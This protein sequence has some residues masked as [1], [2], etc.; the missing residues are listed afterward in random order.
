MAMASGPPAHVQDTIEAIELPTAQPSSPAVVS[1]AHSSTEVKELETTTQGSSGPTRQRSRLRTLTVMIALFSALFIAAL[2]TTIV[3]TAIPT[4]CADLHSAAGYSWI[5]ASYVIATTAV[6]PIWVKLSDIWGRKPILLMAVALY[7][8]SSIICAVST[9]MA[10]LIAS[11]SVQGVSGGGLASLISIVISDLFSMRSRPLFL[12]LLH[13]TWAVAGG[14]GP[15]LGG[16]FTQL[17]SWRWIFWINLPI[18]GAAFCLL[19]LFLDVHNPKTKLADGVK[20]IDWAGSLSIVCVMVMV[21]LGLNFGG[22]AYP[23]DSPKVICLVAVGG[24]MAVVFLFSE[25][26]LA[27]YPIMPLGL[28]RR[29][30]NA[31]CLAIGFTQHFV[32]NAA[33]Y[34]LPLYFQSTKEA[35]PLQSGLLLLPLIITEAFTGIFA[36]VFIYRVGRYMEL[37]W[38]GMA[39]LTVGNGLYIYLNA[40][41]SIGSI[42]AFEVV[43][44]LGGGLLFE[45]PLIAL[46]ALVSQ[47]DTATATATL[48]FI[49][50]IGV[51]LSIVSGGIIFQNGMQ[52]RR[53][54][55][56]DHGLPTNLIETFSGPDAATSIDLIATIPDQAQRLA[57]KQAFAWSLRNVWIMAAGVAACGLLASGL[58]TKKELAKDHTE[59]RT[60]IKEKRQADSGALDGQEAVSAIARSEEAFA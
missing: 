57:V 37:I 43:A 17:L 16:A 53:P 26:R 45:P 56:R 51:S 22:T 30:S 1:S 49:R 8:A 19:L 29:R 47:D 18:S 31:A 50:G 9:S 35:S 41:S 44:G 14:L 36:G 3:A 6:V 39:L 12:G 10:M 52:L 60:G 13:V 40:T 28:F 58:V 27:R 4:I 33:E 55:L 38:A 23:W 5:G 20:A 48:G 11:R 7:F 59:T 42:A 2:N 54:S 21:L 32:I 46:Q 24:L 25:S 15:V 34:Y